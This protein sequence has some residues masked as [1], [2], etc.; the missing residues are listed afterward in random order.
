[1]ERKE[2]KES[3]ERDREGIIKILD[4]LNTLFGLL[5]MDHARSS[6]G[7][8]GESYKPGVFQKN[9]KR[10][11][12]GE[13]KTQFA[14]WG[15]F[16]PYRGPGMRRDNFSCLLWKKK[17]RKKGTGRKTTLLDSVLAPYPISWKKEW[18]SSAPGMPT[19][20]SFEVRVKN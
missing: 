3:A 5:L 17:E 9:Q 19:A 11:K 13:K 16:L 2:K 10:A 1:V 14:I 6:R 8:R 7:Q 12:G 4:K 20:P 15:L 18:L